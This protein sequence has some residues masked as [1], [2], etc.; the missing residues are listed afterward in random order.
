MHE[1]VHINI[2]KGVS[3]KWTLL[4]LLYISRNV[5]KPYL[6]FLTHASEHPAKV[7]DT[8]LLHKKIRNKVL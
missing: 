2:D 7:V 6:P 3:V 4:T 8:L 1:N 5:I